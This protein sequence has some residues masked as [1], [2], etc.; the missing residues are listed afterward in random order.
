[1]FFVHPRFDKFLGSIQRK[2]FF[3][4]LE[5]RKFITS[6]KSE[7][8][9]KF[10]SI[11]TRTKCHLAE[12]S[13][14]ASDDWINLPVF[15]TGNSTIRDI[16]SGLQIS[17]IPRLQEQFISKKKLS[18]LFTEYFYIKYQCSIVSKKMKHKF[19]IKFRI[20]CYNNN[21]CHNR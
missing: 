5:G 21:N 12:E 8:T 14:T 6:K 3:L 16:C 9:I 19:C 10:G 4:Q 17:K 20:W 18:Y 1:V 11:K 7:C 2:M 13:R 15:P